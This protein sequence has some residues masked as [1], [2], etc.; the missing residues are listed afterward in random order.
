MKLN[1]PTYLTLFRLALIPLFVVV[2]YLPITYSPEITTFIF[3]IASITDWFDGYLARKW[4][5][6]TP[7]G[8]F[9]DPVADKVLV[10]VAFVCVVEYYHT[11]WITIPVCI[12]IAREIIISALREWMAELGKRTSVAVSIWGKIK[13]TAQ[14]LALGGMLWRQSDLMETLAF[15]LLYIASAL[16]IWSMLQYLKASKGS[17]LKS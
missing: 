17:L 7:L 14:M 9:L 2:F 6:T 5:Q 8:A 3:F 1:F 10:A 11:W 13:T 15:I 12:M 4:N 16:T